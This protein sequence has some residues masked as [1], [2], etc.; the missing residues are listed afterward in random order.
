MAIRA[1]DDS[2]DTVAAFR[3]SDRRLAKLFRLQKLTDVPALDDLTDDRIKPHRPESCVCA[4]CL[5]P[6]GCTAVMRGRDI[7]L[8]APCYLEMDYPEVRQDC[9]DDGT[10]C[11]FRT[12]QIEDIRLLANMETILITALCI[13]E[14][15]LNYW[16]ASSPSKA[17]LMDS[18]MT[19]WSANTPRVVR[20]RVIRPNEPRSRAVILG[21]LTAGV[22]V[23][24]QGVNVRPPEW[25]PDR[26]L[27]TTETVDV[28]HM[29]SPTWASDIDAVTEEQPAVRFVHGYVHNAAA[30]LTNFP[31]PGSFETVS[32]ALFSEFVTAL[33][34]IDPHLFNPIGGFN[35]AR[36]L[37]DAVDL[38]AAYEATGGSPDGFAR[39]TG[40]RR[41]A[42]D[43][44]SVMVHSLP[45]VKYDGGLAAAVWLI[46]P[47]HCVTQMD[48]VLRAR[49]R[50]LNDALS[51]DDVAAVE[52]AGVT[53]WKVP[54]VVCEAILL[55]AGCMYQ[56]NNL[57]ANAVITSDIVLM[58]SAPYLLERLETVRET[59]ADG[60]DPLA[61]RQMVLR[62]AS[63]TL[64]DLC[65]ILE[66]PVPEEPVYDP[67][68]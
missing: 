19:R 5:T 10:D 64:Q 45:P 9:I 30:R 61:T 32:P 21:C 44:V 49:H 17:F 26:V 11:I 66:I 4:S 36:V 2:Q 34:E 59:P 63:A 68:F 52:A 22:P 41:N 20:P 8:C 46:I 60:A 3:D 37:T 43:A 51:A 42:C 1:M 23:K 62:A 55:P 14:H 25:S 27:E 24:V 12:L 40:L 18:M 50:S 16:R 65:A 13:R 15:L 7:I 56:V 48:A 67:V 6:V 47:K 39:S 57:T 58:S 29:T 54:Q 35:M 28:V 38:R 53:V 33:N 31:C